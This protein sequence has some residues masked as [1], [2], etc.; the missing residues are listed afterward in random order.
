MIPEALLANQRSSAGIRLLAHR[1]PLPR[2]EALIPSRATNITAAPSSANAA[3]AAAPM[4]W[5]APVMIA[6]LPANSFVGRSSLI[7]LQLRP[8]EHEFCNQDWGALRLSGQA[9]DLKPM[10]DREDL[11]V[12]SQAPS[13]TERRASGE[14][15]R[16][17]PRTA[18]ARYQVRYTGRRDRIRGAAQRTVAFTRSHSD[19]C[20][21]VPHYLG[22]LARTDFVE[23]AVELYVLRHCRTRT[24]QLD[25]IVERL[26]EIHDGEAI[27][28]K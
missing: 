17:H 16:R 10:R 13:V 22:Q 24:K 28:I 11:R 9:A 21:N 5:L 25:V 12:R 4:P 18:C 19:L 3:A 6:T 15:F 14:R 26:L 7:H 27:A 20:R 2:L 1:R 23:E 8:S